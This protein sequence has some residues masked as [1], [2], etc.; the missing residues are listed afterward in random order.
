MATEPVNNSA[1]W[2]M[3]IRVMALAQAAIVALLTIAIIPWSVWVTTSVMEANSRIRAIDANTADRQ[4]GPRYTTEQARSAEREAEVERLK[5]KAELSRQL[6]D[7]TTTIQRDLSTI[8]DSVAAV[9]SDIAVI[10]ATT[11]RDKRP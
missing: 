1:R 7:S 9:K 10:R 3:I 2:A 8:K 11:E 6:A 5:L 4:L